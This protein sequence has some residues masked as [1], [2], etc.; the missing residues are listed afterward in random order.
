[1]GRERGER[2]KMERERGRTFESRSRDNISI[3]LKTTFP[4][5]SL[6]SINYSNLICI[7]EISQ[8]FL[9]ISAINLL[10]DVVL[11]ETSLYL[12]W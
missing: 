4:C 10:L 3:N 12:R 11:I 1:M 8:N 6:A 9:Q 7:A 5:T 2:W